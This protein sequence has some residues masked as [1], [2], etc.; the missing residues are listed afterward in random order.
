MIRAPLAKP[1]HGENVPNHSTTVGSAERNT[2]LI[3]M[4]TAAATTEE[5]SLRF[6][7]PSFRSGIEPLT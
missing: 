3:T 4:M 7:M 5:R 2:K 1:N 6:K